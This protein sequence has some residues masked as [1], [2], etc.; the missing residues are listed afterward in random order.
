MAA[1]EKRSS[2]IHGIVGPPGSGKTAFATTLALEM[3][4]RFAKQPESKR[5]SVWCTWPVT[6]KRVNFL[7]SW[8]EGLELSNAVI[9]YDE[10]ARLFGRRSYTKNKEEDLN[11]FRVHR[12]DGLTLYWI[13]HAIEDVETKIAEELTISIWHVNRLFGPDLDEQPTPLENWFGWWCSA[14]RYSIR[15]YQAV[16]KRKPLGMPRWFRIDRLF[17]KYDSFYVPGQRD[18]SGSRV[19]RSALASPGSESD[20][21]AELPWHPV[22][23]P[24]VWSACRVEELG[25]AVVRFEPTPSALNTIEAWRE[26]TPG[27]LE[28]SNVD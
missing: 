22:C 9:M 11:H 24:G 18:G 12:H 6:D 3:V 23:G 19:G 7:R 28:V 1:K 27:S 13:A 14:R 21:A 2:L 15:D 26:Y 10:F 25:G 8:E 20:T 4:E 5:R 17:E 16:T